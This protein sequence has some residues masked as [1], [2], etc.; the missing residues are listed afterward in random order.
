MQVYLHTY[1]NNERER[2]LTEKP[3]AMSFSGSKKPSSEQ[4]PLGQVTVNELDVGTSSPPLEVVPTSNLEKNAF[5]NLSAFGFCFAVLNT[6]VV[7]VV[8]LGSSLASGGPS[9]GTSLLKNA[10][11]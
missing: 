10:S 11:G 3:T 8:G 6:W 1:T 9:A 2:N 4:L 5:S 7:L